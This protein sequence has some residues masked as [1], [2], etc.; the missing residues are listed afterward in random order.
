MELVKQQ[1]WLVMRQ[2]INEDDVDVNKVINA[3]NTKAEAMNKLKIYL[4]VDDGL[5]YVIRSTHTW[6]PQMVDRG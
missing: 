3:F 4:K 5:K 6:F 2:E 1:I